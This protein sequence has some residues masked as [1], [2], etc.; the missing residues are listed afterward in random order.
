MAE[1]A[2]LVELMQKQML[3]QQQQMEELVNRLAPL[4]EESTPKVAS[5]PVSIPKFTSFDP[6]SELWKDYLARFDTFTQANSIP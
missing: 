3:M 2:T 1:F 4:R 5:T 6:T